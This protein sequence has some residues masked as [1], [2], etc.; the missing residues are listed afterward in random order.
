MRLQRALLPAQERAEQLT[1]WL[2]KPHG[3]LGLITSIDGSQLITLV[4]DTETNTANCWET[5]LEGN[6]YQSLTPVTPQCHWF[7]RN[8]WD[9]FGLV[10]DGH[11][12]LKHNLLHE[13]YSPDLFPL[14]KTVQ[15]DYPPAE[16]TYRFLEVTGD[17]V[18]EIPVGPI[19]AG[20]I[21]P[22]HFRFS[23]LGEIIFNLE[24][25]LGYVHRGVEKRLCEVPWKNQRFVAEAAASDTSSANALAHAVAIESILDL[26]AT[27]RAN[28]LRSISLEIERVAMHISDLG[29][30]AGDIG[31]LG[32][33]SSMARLRGNALRLAEL[34]T[35]SRLQRGFICPGG[36]TYDSSEHLSQLR[37]STLLLQKDLKPVL[38]FFLSNQVARDRMERIGV[39]SPRLAKDFGLVGV[40]GRGSEQSYDARGHFSHGVYP[41]VRPI[42]IV[43][44]DGD[45]LARANVRIAELQNSLNLIVELVDLTPEGALM[46][47][48][49]DKLSGDQIGVGIVES[50]R[51]ELIHL[52]FTD[53]HGAVVRY[54]IKDPSTNNWTGLAIAARSNLVSDF[55]LCNKSFALSYSG[56]DL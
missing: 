45:V 12:R 35:G 13:S 20:I 31:F 28:F 6:R 52:V 40:T 51:G 49:P 34:L 50:H 16:K 2:H 41:E 22:A 46:T 56:H 55:P 5:P 30:L 21:E 15:H 19:H 1:Q 43:K 18:Y 3:R 42:F 14:S 24:I 4:L 53:Q 47:P 48:M 29:G 11:P 25:R 33:S 32:V 38:E 23:C 44:N 17:G 54:A 27:P 9:L 8:L 39:V 37:E 10:P 7:E 26:A 36:V